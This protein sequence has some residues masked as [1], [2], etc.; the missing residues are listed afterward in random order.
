MRVARPLFGLLLCS[1]CLL[2]VPLR[3][4]ASRPGDP[5]AY[6]LRV[7][8]QPLAFQAAVSQSW[9]GS[10]ARIEYSPLRFLDV[11]LDG[12]VAWLNASQGALLPHS[13]LARFGLAFHIVQSVRQ[14]QLYGTV[15][16]SDTA[17]IS[18]NGIGVAQ[19]LMEMPSS[20]RLRTGLENP[21]D[22][23]PNLTATM[24]DVH[25]LRVG[26]AYTKILQRA[27]PESDRRALNEL[28]FAYV[29][30]SFGTHWNLVADVTGKRE[31]GYRRFYGDVLLT[32]SDLNDAEPRVRSNG[33]R[34][35]FRPLGA[36]AG[37]QGALEGLLQDFPS[38]GVSYDMEIGLYPGRGGF[39]GYLFF[40]LGVAIDAATR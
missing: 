8:L 22:R 10:A 23:D 9:F 1:L 26:A 5:F 12:R 40:A 27:R 34:I 31:V 29:G 38:F 25:S 2:V 7:A 35:D 18:P 36:R 17:A 37:M 39:E 6:D 28:P 3:V 32:T 21:Y 16:P 13:Y 14:K 33:E 11:S 24:R 15:Y 4:H 20:N 30:Y 19:D